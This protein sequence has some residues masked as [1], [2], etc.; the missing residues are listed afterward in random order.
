MTMIQYSIVSFNLP[1]NLLRPFP[2]TIAHYFVLHDSC[3][4]ASPVILLFAGLQGDM[5]RLAKWLVCCIYWILSSQCEFGLNL[6]YALSWQLNY[7]PSLQANSVV[8]PFCFGC[9]A[10][11]AGF[12]EALC[13][14]TP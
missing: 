8:V 5:Q 6:H 1:F 7:I 14:P 12:M 11:Y 9:P 3:A 4:D 2:G 13:K 10:L